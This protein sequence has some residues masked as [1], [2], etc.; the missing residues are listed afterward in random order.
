M[1]TIKN[2]AALALGLAAS[3]VWSASALAQLPTQ[4]TTN[5]HSNNVTFD[6]LEPRDPKWQ[7][8]YERLKQRRVLE[9]F[10]EFFSP[11]RLP[12]TFRM[13][14]MECGQANAFYDPNNTWSFQ[15]CYEYV[16]KF[17]KAAP[18]VPSLTGPTRGE[19]IVGSFVSTVLHETGHALSDILKLPVL[20]REEDTA[21]QISAYLMLQFGKELARPTI[22]GTYYKWMQ[23]T[24][25]DTSFYWDVHSTDRQRALNYLCLAYGSDPETFKDFVER[26][27]MPQERARNCAREYQQVKSAFDQTIGPYID[28]ALMAKVKATQWL[29]PEDFN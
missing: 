22:K 25:F 16:D 28:P 14:S 2:A 9:Q 7:P 1:K 6:Y 11:L 27:L 26:G 17:D 24:R 13:K 4:P 10:S 23:D 12:V 8:V 19:F 15:L 20:G 3:A 29:K 18:K 21:D 5:L